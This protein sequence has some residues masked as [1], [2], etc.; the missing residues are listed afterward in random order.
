ML[1]ITHYIINKPTRNQLALNRR[2]LLIN[3]I[4]RIHLPQHGINSQWANQTH[5]TNECEHFLREMFGGGDSSQRERTQD[6]CK[7]STKEV[8]R[9]RWSNGN[10]NILTYNEHI[11][12]HLFHQPLPQCLP[13]KH[14]FKSLSNRVC[15]LR[16]YFVC[17]TCHILHANK[18][19][20]ICVI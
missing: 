1:N 18:L 16:V 19:P 8:K 5:N 9:T 12:I 15:A 20:H 4:K 14:T 2:K 6:A 3:N 7:S 13:T 10:A 17:E 11:W